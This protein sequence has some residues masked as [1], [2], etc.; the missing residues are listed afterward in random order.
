M[1]WLQSNLVPAWNDSSWSIIGGGAT[2]ASDKITLPVN[3]AVRLRLNSGAALMGSEYIKF[4]VKFSGT[5]SEF[6]EYTPNC[7]IDVK[8][9]YVDGT[10][11]N[12]RI[13]LSKYSLVSGVYTD[14]TALLVELKTV[15]VIDVYFKN[16]TTALGTL[17]INSIEMYKSEDVNKE[18]VAN[19]VGE[20]TKPLHLRAY[21]G[22]T[23]KGCTVEYKGTNEISRLEFISGTSGEFLGILIDDEDF[24]QYTSIAGDFPDS[25]V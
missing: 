23:R 20:A 15:S 1:N 7:A 11:Q 21:N 6:D 3:S 14:E 5:F 19:A 22:T 2:I 10:I 24:F 25:G 17:Y 9:T 4:V 13:I 12:S 18:Q 16:F 8:I